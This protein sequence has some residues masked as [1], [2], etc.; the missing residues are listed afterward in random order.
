MSEP[1]SMKIA[2][3]RS[4]L[5]NTLDAIDEKLN[6]PKRVGKLAAKAQASYTANPV[7]WRIT[8]FGA[9]VAVGALITFAL[10][11]DD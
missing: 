11:S 1:I 7:P 8:A 2:S 6:V 5:E 4:E 9:V 10:M 3:T